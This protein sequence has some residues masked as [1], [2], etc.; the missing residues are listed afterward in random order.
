MKKIA[1]ALVLAFS[2][3]QAEA[4]NYADSVA[5]RKIFNEVLTNGECYDWL[6]DLCKDVGHRLR[7]RRRPT[8]LSGGEKL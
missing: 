4:Q 2:F 7:V 6:H 3:Y 1:V 8:W 5:F